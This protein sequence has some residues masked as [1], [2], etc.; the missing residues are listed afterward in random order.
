MGSSVEERSRAGSLRRSI[1]ILMLTMGRLH[2]VDGTWG[3]A[4]NSVFAAGPRKA[5]GNLDRAGRLHDLPDANSLLASSSAS[6]YTN[7]TSL[8]EVRSKLFYITRSVRTSQRTCSTSI[9]R[10]DQL[11]LFR[12][13]IGMI[14]TDQN[15]NQEEIRRRLNSGNACY[16]SVQ[17]LLF[18]HLLY[19]NV[20]I[21][22]YETI[23]FPVVLYGC[24]TWSLILME[25]H[26]L[27][28]GC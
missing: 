9:T 19:E 10:M 21:R 3:L 23:I 20:K 8:T 11:M 25:E 14:I 28:T 16:H 18:S 15:L 12:E 22:I 27:R 1:G 7:L 2:M 13:I 6:A 5:T 24:E 17:N 26:R 4:T